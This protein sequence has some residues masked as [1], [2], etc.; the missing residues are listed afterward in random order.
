[1]VA[2]VIVGAL[3]VA[4]RAA[5]KRRFQA[6]NDTTTKFAVEEIVD[7][8]LED[9]RVVNEISAERPWQSRVAW[10][11]VVAALGVVAPVVA[12]LF[13]YDL[14][15]EQIVEFGSALVTLAGAAYALSGRFKSGLKPLFS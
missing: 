8:V 15:G 7:E 1:M 4:V 10:G 3:T 9:Q 2:P 14:S 12:R 6:V 5:L 13:G 11:S